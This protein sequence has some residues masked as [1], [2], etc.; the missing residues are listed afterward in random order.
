MCATSLGSSLSIGVERAVDPR[1][2]GY[3]RLQL[4]AEL[5]PVR[6]THQQLAKQSRATV[7]HQL[8][9]AAIQR[10]GPV[11]VL[12]PGMAPSRFRDAFDVDQRDSAERDTP[13]ADAKLGASDL[14]S[15]PEAEDGAEDQGGDH[16]PD[17][18]Q[19]PLDPSHGFY[20]LRSSVTGNSA[21]GS[22]SGIGRR[23]G[24]W[25]C[26]KNRASRRLSAS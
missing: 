6:G 7:D 19:T 16:D 2:G 22:G 8:P 20:R 11:L 23:P 10:V 4:L 3:R 25:P 21:L 13:E 12:D 5:V 24:E 14:V 9:M 18:G 1:G 26:G 17:P 15:K